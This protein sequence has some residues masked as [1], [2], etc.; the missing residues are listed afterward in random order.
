MSISL[1]PIYNRDEI[2][3][4]ITPH[5][6]GTSYQVVSTG[7]TTIEFIKKGLSK[8]NIFITNNY[9]TPEHTYITDINDIYHTPSDGI[10]LLSTTMYTT[11]LFLKSIQFT[12]KHDVCIIV[13][14]I[15][16]RMDIPYP[17]CLVE[18]NHE[19]VLMNIIRKVTPYA[20]T[21]YICCNNYY[22][23][24][25]QEVESLTESNVVF[26]YFDSIDKS[27]TYPKGNG[28][29][30]FQVLTNI[31]NVTDHL[32]I[33]WGD[34]L[35]SDPR[36]FEEMYNTT[37]DTCLIPVHYEKNP[38]AYLILDNTNH[39]KQIEYKKNI[40]VEYGYH[41]QCI[42]LCN[43]QKIMEALQVLILQE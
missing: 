9:L 30:I 11:N 5:L 31:Q 43:K 3:Q 10:K 21:I 20:N 8:R 4:S 7:K 23:H 15:N 33:M 26:L 2:I 17:K 41:D 29:T 27:Q 6:E 38:Y 12:T 40:N 35:I 34:I 19:M 36:I 1:K 42:F 25:F 14:G 13:G 16:S 39:V 28:E 18:I 37:W 24:Q 32:F 22:Q